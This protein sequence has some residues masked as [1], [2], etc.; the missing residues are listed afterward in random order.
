MDQDLK[1][2]VTPY[3]RQLD[4][5]LGELRPM[6]NECMSTP[7]DEQLLRETDELERLKLVNKYS[8]VLSSLMFSYV[9]LLAGH[10][11]DGLNDKVM[12]ELQRVRGY[13]ERTK[14]LE[15]KL[16]KKLSDDELKKEQVKD[17]I[18][19]ALEPSVSKKNFI[20]NKHIKFENKDRVTKR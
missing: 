5:K 11:S 20:K 16:T 2:S 6:I 13:I 19:K 10:D 15:Q 4:K 7:L 8:Y 9:K 12:V 3:I 18:R 1:K 17:H 14:K